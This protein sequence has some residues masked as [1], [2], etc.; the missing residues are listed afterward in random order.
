MYYKKPISDFKCRICGSTKYH[1]KLS[2]VGEL[3]MW[4]CS[5]CS[6]LFTKPEKFSCNRILHIKYLD[7]YNYDQW[8]PV[9]YKYQND[10]GFDLRAAIEYPITIQPYSE[11]KTS[12]SVNVWIPFGIKIQPSHTDMDMK[13]FCRSGLALKQGVGILN[14][15]GVIDNHYRGELMNRFVN[16]G[17]CPYTI[18]PGERVAQMVIEKR[19]DVSI[20]EV[21]VWNE[22]TDR[23]AGGFGHSGKL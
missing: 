5:D 23:G 4:E 16:L 19:L 6:T 20:T 3:N 12:L 2:F 7:N 18:Q 15:V 22:E 13:I 21:D 9:T 11:V 8:G 1:R 10:S 17:R 14:S